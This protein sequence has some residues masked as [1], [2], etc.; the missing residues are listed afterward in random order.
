R[1]D[2]D[3]RHPGAVDI[4]RVDRVVVPRPDAAGPRDGRWNGVGYLPESEGWLGVAVQVTARVDYK[5]GIEVDEGRPEARVRLGTL[6]GA[7]NRARRIPR[8]EVRSYPLRTGLRVSGCA[9]NHDQ[10]RL[11]G[12]HRDNSHLGE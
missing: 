10:R 2:Q 6:W 9:L 4:L 5:S 11:R 3:L 7:L 8:V 1:G 12:T